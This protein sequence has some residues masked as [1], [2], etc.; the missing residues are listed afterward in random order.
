MSTAA[1]PVQSAFSGG[2][3]SRRIQSRV[4]Q[5]IYELGLETME[6]FVP[7]VEGPAMK[8]SGFRHVL[9]AHASASW[10]SEFR[11]NQTQS[12]PMGWQEE[13]IQFF[14][15]NAAIIGT[16]AVPYTAAQAPNV[17]TQQSGDRQYLAHENH[18]PSR[19]TRTGST[20]FT[21]DT[22]PLINGPYADLNRNEA[23]TVTVSGTAVG[24]SVTITATQPIFASGHVGALFRIEAKDLSDIP[25]WEPGI[26]GV[27]SGSTL[28]KSDG[29]VYLAASSGRTGTVQ[30]THD[31]GT[32]WDG[33][34]TGVDVNA[35]GPFGVQWTYQYDMSGSLQITA[36]AVDGLSATATVL[37]RLPAAL[38]SVASAYWQHGA[39]S[40][41]NGW[42]KIVFIWQQ[43]LCWMTDFYIYAS[44]SGDFLNHQDFTSN[45]LL[46]PD[47]AFRRRLSISDPV[48]GAVVDRDGVYLTTASGEY[49]ITLMD[50]TSGVTGTNIKLVDQGNR[51]SKRIRPLKI[52]GEVVFADRSGRKVMAAEY[53]F[54]RDR[55]PAANLTAPARHITGTG[56]K[57]LLWAQSP[58][59][60]LCAVRQDGQ[61]AVHAHDPEQQVR[62]WSRI[63][64]GA[65]GQILS[66]IATPNPD[67]DGDDIWALIQRDGVKSWE[68]QMPLW[69]E[70]RMV[71]TDA[72]FV[73]SGVIESG[74]PA[75]TI[76]APHLAGRTVRLLLDGKTAPDQVVPGDGTITLPYQASVRVAG[77]PYEAR[78]KSLRFEQR[79][80][81]D[82]TNQD[83]KKRMVSVLARLID[84]GQLFVKAGASLNSFIRRKPADPMGEAMPLHNGDTPLQPAGGDWERP[85]QWEVISDDALP[86]MV[87][88]MISKV[89]F[90]TS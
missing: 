61:L 51:G 29:K 42:P 48:L 86:C 8:R 69:D 44:V 58:E 84:T 13:A 88:A 65:G 80:R 49:I 39:F 23:A 90:A 3:F 1:T 34:Q 24:S 5:P 63:K 85:A 19:L 38:T 16:L 54:D 67:G 14:T 35:K 30:P 12:Y 78:L 33:M 25:A 31:V 74:A 75:S 72:F 81:Y 47:L 87:T 26:D 43:R 9:A 59:Q 40:A 21:H 2:E 53:A 73:D 22:A 41:A 27:V 4:D 56:V 7:T 18:P 37:R 28:R 68:R 10:I 71:Q 89:E 55:Y 64:L 70:D 46:A 66:A 32:E 36:V 52:A 20:S 15:N 83:K 6:N 77:L 60:L 11:Y 45:G 57:Q 79:D 17:W 62:G 50:P 76:S 82:Q